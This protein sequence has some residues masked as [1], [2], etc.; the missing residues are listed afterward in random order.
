MYDVKSKEIYEIGRFKIIKEEISKNGSLH[1]FSFVDMKE[2]ICVIP[3]IDDKYIVLREYRHAINSYVY[4]FVCGSVEIG[5]NPKE[6][7]KK[8]LIEEIGFE[9]I[10]IKELGYFYPSYGSTNEKIHLYVADVT[11]ISEPK[12]EAL[13]DISYKLLSFEETNNIEFTGAAEIIC[14]QRYKNHL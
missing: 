4:G 13:E 3:K 7:V 9:A 11:K 14:W 5:E 6:T 10:E 8:E 12:K 2:G 1:P